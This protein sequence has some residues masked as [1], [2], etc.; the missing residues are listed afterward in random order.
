MLLEV[1]QHFNI[2]L[3]S[4]LQVGRILTLGRRPSKLVQ[5]RCSRVFEF[6]AVQKDACE[7]LSAATHC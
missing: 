6:P 1:V 3:A 7:P 5:G 4:L 2:K